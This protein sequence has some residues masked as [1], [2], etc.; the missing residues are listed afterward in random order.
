MKLSRNI[1]KNK[2]NL[3]FLV[4]FLLISNFSFAQ[5][6]KE[7]KGRVIDSDTNDPLAFA[8]LVVDGTNISTVTNTNGKFIL[9]VPID[10][11]NKIVSISYLGYKKEELALS[12]LKKKNNKIE[13]EESATV[14]VEI[15]LINLPKDAEALVRKSLK[16]RGGNYLNNEVTMTGFYR[17]TI[18]KRHKDAS[19]S[20]AVVKIHKRPY[21]SNKRDVI[22]LVKARKNTNYARL[23]TIALKLQGGPFSTLYTDFMKYPEYIFSEN[24]LSHYNFT[25]GKSTQTNDKLIYLVHF[26]QKVDVNGVLYYGKLFIDADTYALTSAIYNLNVKNREE[27]SKF[28]VRKKPKKATV[29]PTEAAY[30]V[31]YR[32]KGG[33]WYYGYSNI[34]LSFIVKWE[35]KWFKS[36]YTLQSEM[37]ITD[38]K[39]NNAAVNVKHRDRL[40]P[41]MILLDEASGFSDPE[42]WG[43]YNIIEP[44]KS[45]EAAIRKIRK[46]LK[47]VKP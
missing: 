38:W 28:F 36:R 22:T 7:F 21:E 45:I 31:N 33:K 17:E 39:I 43:E 37:A 41:N 13:L 3:M 32:V 18:K 35:N 5:N 46:Q 23:D 9:K 10:S 34:K 11:Q 4:C 14:L 27:A 12:S 44:E 29:Y 8:T 2:L 26:E 25:F 42:F 16:K 15:D 47:K 6:T 20:E 40:K 24:D 30:Q 19:L 1:L